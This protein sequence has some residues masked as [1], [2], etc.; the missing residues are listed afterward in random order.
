MSGIRRHGP[1]ANGLAARVEAALLDDLRNA[2]P[3]ATNT[4]FTLTAGP[5]DRLDSGLTASTSYGWLLIK[6]LWVDPAQRGTGL[7][8]RMMMRA[9]E[10]GSALGCHSAWLAPR[11][12]RRAAS[13]SR[14]ATASSA[15]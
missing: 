7:G 12:P 2:L 10:E 3:Q 14:S 4:A 9:E 13:T 11:T 1:E 5:E 6:T 15:G 8:R